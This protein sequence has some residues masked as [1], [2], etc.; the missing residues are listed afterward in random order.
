MEI[1]SLI[2]QP[3]KRWSRYK[4]ILACSSGVIL[5]LIMNIIWTFNHAMESRITRPL[6]YARQY[7][8]MID[9]QHEI[10]TNKGA[11]WMKYNFKK[12]ETNFVKIPER[13][14]IVWSAF[15]DNRTVG[16][17]SFKF[18]DKSRSGLVLPWNV[19]H[20]PAVVLLGL[21]ERK[22]STTY[23]HMYFSNTSFREARQ[24]RKRIAKVVTKMRMLKFRPMHIWRN[25]L[26]VCDVN[27]HFVETNN[28]GLPILVGLSPSNTTQPER[29]I[30]VQPFSGAKPK[31]SIGI[32]VSTIYGSLSPVNFAQFIEYYRGMGVNNFYLYE[33]LNI[34]KDLSKLLTWYE[35]KGILEYIPWRLP[36]GDK[37]YPKRASQD[38]F[39]NLVQKAGSTDCIYRNYGRHKWMLHVDVDEFIVPKL[40][41][42]I[43]QIITRVSNQKNYPQ[44][45]SSLR[46]HHVQF[47]IDQAPNN[48]TDNDKDAEFDLLF[49]KYQMSSKPWPMQF[50]GARTKFLSNPSGVEYVGSHQVTLKLKDFKEVN[51]DPSIATMHHYRKSLLDKKFPCDQTNTYAL[52][53]VKELRRRVKFVIEK[54]KR[55]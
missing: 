49:D 6:P 5:F 40:D 18:D 26:F 37:S 47:C 29:L 50:W 46:F 10:S 33:A 36:L 43:D 14:L 13:D 21:S 9:R 41:M 53:Y 32:C 48:R 20:R 22:M 28:L 44:K 39:D 55:Y 24:K 3:L 23:C 51:V 35:K 4:T 30:N 52:K 27:R 2:Y 25:N 16:D 12:L 19:K 34:T 15:Y 38:F 45:V 7:S 1:S 17:V 54:S 11:G 8:I 31:N 42:T